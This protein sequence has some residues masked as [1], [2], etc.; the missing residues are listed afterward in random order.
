MHVAA[1]VPTDPGRLYLSLD[2]AQVQIDTHHATHLSLRIEDRD[3]KRYEH[4]RPSIQGVCIWV[5]HRFPFARLRYQVVVTR[6]LSLIVLV[7]FEDPFAR[8]VPR[9]GGN[10]SAS[11]VGPCSVDE[12]AVLAVERVWRKDRPD[13]GKL[14]VL[15]NEKPHHRVCHGP[16][17]HHVG[18]P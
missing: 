11:L 1:L 10:E 17:K 12:L 15:F 3:G 4:H 9:P 2:I 18:C 8:R 7:C 5:D 6:A 16:R 13:I 14:C